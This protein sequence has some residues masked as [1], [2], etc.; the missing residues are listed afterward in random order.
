VRQRFTRGGQ[1][2]RAIL[3]VAW[4]RGGD[5][6]FQPHASPLG[7]ARIAC[8]PASTFHPLPPPLRP[9]HARLK[10]VFDP[11]RIFNRCRLYPDL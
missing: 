5:Y 2:C 7:Q 3:Q 9:L 10:D 11:A 1:S 8:D 6:L 4:L